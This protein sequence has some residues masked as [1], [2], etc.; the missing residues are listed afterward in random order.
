MTRSLFLSVF[1]CATFGGCAASVS[2]L[3]ARA[4]FD[5]QCAANSLTITRIDSDTMGVSGCG[6]RATYVSRCNGQPGQ[7]GTTCTWVRN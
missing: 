4:A 7:L 6:R 1:F 2:Q 5:F 3:R